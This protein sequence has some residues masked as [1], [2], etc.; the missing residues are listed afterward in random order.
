[1][2]SMVALDVIDTFLES[3]AG[4]FETLD[5]GVVTL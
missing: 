3:P 1:M 4:C 2:Q 5:G